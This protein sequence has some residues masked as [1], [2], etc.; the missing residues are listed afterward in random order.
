M[1]ATFSPLWERQEELQAAMKEEYTRNL[2]VQIE[3]TRY[4]KLHKRQHE[5][6]EEWR[7]RHGRRNSSAD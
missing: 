7:Q 6:Q 3:Q 5:Q 2:N 4:Q 1:F